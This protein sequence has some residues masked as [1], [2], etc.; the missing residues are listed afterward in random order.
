MSLESFFNTEL[1]EWATNIDFY[2]SDL[3]ILEKRLE[4]VAQK[5]TKAPVLA[6]VEH[7]QNQ[8]IVERETLRGLKH[9]VHVNAEKMQEEIKKFSRIHNLDIVDHHSL[10]R[11]SVQLSEKIFLELKHSFYRFLSK[12]L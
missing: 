4:E 5:N 1:N 12:V 6:S 2:I 10:L 7:F 8:F 9:A 3:A 11:E